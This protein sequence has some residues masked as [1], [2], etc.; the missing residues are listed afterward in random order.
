MASVL[1]KILDI[2]A[3][4]VGALAGL[5]LGAL[6]LIRVIGH[7][8]VFVT[9]GPIFESIAG[10]LGA[11]CL[12][13]AA[14]AELMPDKTQKRAEPVLWLA[15]IGLVMITIQTIMKRYEL[16]PLSN[17]AATILGVVYAISCWGA[18]TM[19]FM[20]FVKRRRQKLAGRLS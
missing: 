12:L 8:A 7:V 3:V 14:E 6:G 1:V 15:H 10:V 9:G 18:A 20:I 4:S 16:E 13:I 5:A 2:I 11:L 17:Q 19:A